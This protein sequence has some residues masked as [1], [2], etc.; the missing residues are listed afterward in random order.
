MTYHSYKRGRNFEQSRLFFRFPLP[1]PVPF[2]E[3]PLSIVVSIASPAGAAWDRSL[4]ARGSS[5][6]VPGGPSQ[7][8]RPPCAPQHPARCLPAF[9]SRPA[10][11]ALL[12]P[13][14]ACKPCRL[15]AVTLIEPAIFPPRWGLVDLCLAIYIYFSCQRSP[16][17]NQVITEPVGTW[18]VDRRGSRSGS[19]APVS[20]RRLASACRYRLTSRTRCVLESPQR[21]GVLCVPA[22][23][24][25]VFLSILSPRLDPA[26]TAPSVSEA[27]FLLHK[28]NSLV[29]FAWL[30]YQIVGIVEEVPFPESAQRLRPAPRKCPVH[31]HVPGAA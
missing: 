29:T 31:Q 9:P 27:R 23:V 7:T 10:T 24:A 5:S 3:T 15:L 8:T 11:C 20:R 16:N 17:E 28:P 18:G 4:R 14:A 19:K 22:F 25:F 26:G 1:R 6:T 21:R 13:L 12:L 2:S 30:C